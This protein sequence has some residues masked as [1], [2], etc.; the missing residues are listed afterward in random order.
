MINHW[1]QLF[2]RDSIHFDRNLVYRFEIYFKAETKAYTAVAS[3]HNPDKLGARYRKGKT[4]LNSVPLFSVSRIV[5]LSR[6]RMA[7][8]SNSIHSH[9]DPFRRNGPL[10][11]IEQFRTHHL[12]LVKASTTSELPHRFIEIQSC[13]QLSR[14]F[15]QFSESNGSETG[16]SSHK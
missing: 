13:F 12:I 1:D 2:D 5:A 3:C 15:R 14:R 11:A 6:E 8:S 7:H 16:A 9:S 4:H 10:A